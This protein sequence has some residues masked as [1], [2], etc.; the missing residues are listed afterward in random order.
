MKAR[1]CGRR[2]LLLTGLLA[3]GQIVSTQP[4]APQPAVP[5]DPLSGI[6]EAFRSHALVALA[7]GYHNNEPGHAF[8]LALV[9][10]P[11]FAAVV[12][13]IVVEFGSARFQDLMDRFVAGEPVADDELRHVWE[14]TTAANAVWDVPIYEEFF[15]AVRSLNQSAPRNRQL[16]VLLGDPPF[17]WDNVKTKDDFARVTKAADRDGHAATVVRREVLAKNR[18]ALI[19]YG[20]GHLARRDILQ[21]FEPSP[22]LLPQLEHDPVQRVFSIWTDLGVDLNTIQRGVAEWPKPS[23]AVLR[24]TVLG[25]ADFTSYLPPPPPPRFRATGNGPDFSAPLPASAYHSLR[26]EEQFDA[27][28]YLGP[29]SAITMSRLSRARCADERYLTMRVGRMELAGMQAAA[30]RLKQYCTALLQ[31]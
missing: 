27:L 7:E 17:D 19:V 5:V 16:R 12:N 30:A 14:D 26:M 11:R 20:D 13:D 23:L 21:N 31:Q 6:L 3:C 9:R 10:D 24:G 28:L 29:Q 25:A 8:R 18:R 22:F 2:A 4:P 1:T 15:R